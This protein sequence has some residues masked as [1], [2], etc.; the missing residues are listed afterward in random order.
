[1][2]ENSDKIAVFMYLDADDKSIEKD[3]CSN[4]LHATGELTDSIELYVYLDR[5]GQDTRSEDEEE[6]DSFDDIYTEWQDKDKKVRGG[7]LYGKAVLQPDNTWRIQ[8][9]T[10][11][12]LVVR[13]S[14]LASSLDDFLKWAEPQT[15]AGHYIVFMSDHGSGMQ[16]GFSDDAIQENQMMPIQYSSV[17][18][19][20]A[21]KLDVIVFD[22][23]L[24]ANAEGLGALSDVAR[25]AVASEENVEDT[26]LDYAAMFQNLAEL[27]TTDA[28]A[29][30]EAIVRG[31]M[32]TDTYTT[33]SGAPTLAAIRLSDQLTAALQTFGRAS[34]N[35]TE[36]DWSALV[37]AFHDGHHY[38]LSYYAD[39]VELM[40]DPVLSKNTSQT[41]RDA[42]SAL[43]AAVTGAVTLRKTGEE[44]GYG[45]TV[46]S[47]IRQ[48]KF[49]EDKFGYLSQLS[50]G[51]DT[52]WADFLYRLYQKA[53]AVDKVH[54]ELPEDSE[55]NTYESA[56]IAL[57]MASGPFTCEDTKQIALTGNGLVHTAN[58]N[59]NQENWL[60]FRYGGAF[61]LPGT[62]YTLN[63]T[64]SPALDTEEIE[65]GDIVI[66]AYAATQREDTTTLDLAADPFEVYENKAGSATI[67]IAVEN[68]K[69]GMYAL[70]IFSEKAVSYTFEGDHRKAGEAVAATEDRFDLPTFVQE[71]EASSGNHNPENAES[72][73]EY[74]CGALAVTAD[75]EEESNTDWFCFDSDKIP[76]SVIVTAFGTSDGVQL[77]V[78][79]LNVMLW[80]KD[81]EGRIV[82][83]A[84]AAGTLTP[85]GE[86]V[87]S[88]SDKVEFDGD[89][90]LSVSTSL[91]GAACYY[92]I[93]LEADDGEDGGG[94]GEEEEENGVEENDSPYSRGFIDAVSSMAI[95]GKAGS[96]ALKWADGHDTR[97]DDDIRY[98][99]QFSSDDF[100]TAFCI[101]LSH[102]AVKIYNVDEG[103]SYD[104]RVR[105]ML[106]DEGGKDEEEEEE[107]PGEEEK[108][109]LSAS[110][111]E[112]EWACADRPLDGNAPASPCVVEAQNDFLLDYLMGRANGT[113]SGGYM[114]KHVGFVGGWTGTGERAALYG[115]NR[116]TDVFKG[117]GED[118]ASLI[119][120]DDGNGDA[121][122]AD[123]IY[124]ARPE[125]W[126]GSRLIDITEV[127]AGAGD[128]IVDFTS[129]KFS[130]GYAEQ[131]RLY[132]GDG[133]D[134]LWAADTETMLFGDS[135][136]D[137][138]T[139]STK[140][141]V[142][143]G[144]SGNDIMT[145][146]GGS[147]IF[148][149][150]EN[151]GTDVVH[152]EEDG[153][154]ILWF[155]KAWG[156]WNDK[157]LTYSDGTNSVEVRGVAAD[158]IS[159]YIGEAGRKTDF[160]ELKEDLAFASHA[161]S[162][163]FG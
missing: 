150:C 163:I 156:T 51:N 132:G 129:R 81:E 20:Y 34:A 99:L 18:K 152:Q 24:M 151:W 4:L 161:S 77:D 120:T 148:C 6:E 127:Q 66:R 39:L 116:I 122:F 110:G 149:F 142:L 7:S 131:M 125:N 33:V 46:Y 80:D 54:R 49:P 98:E 47:P 74:Y 135:G 30:A 100:E 22:A 136:D 42:A 146:G 38:Y 96:F 158:D 70:Q 9:D 93:R 41:L 67:G 87:C 145:G 15:D 130:N 23:C 101:T 121:V 50:A 76:G 141:D 83:K 108:K 21:K 57:P 2:V 82:T 144:G 1:M 32:S 97:N 79:D 107:A 89:D 105:T 157:T 25:Y 133:N 95:P 84:T 71:E 11:G 126:N 112:T 73:T 53:K 113:W 40:T 85:S 139:G 75:T 55:V 8:W 59:V 36:D 16:G 52:P 60:C 48:D 28:R 14:S 115:K 153:E 61:S 109:M 64:F 118:A 58:Y 12:G 137:C 91:N 26:G 154:V 114:A 103:V 140:D 56:M 92:E 123:D 159:I 78:K 134:V 138:L 13:D 63:F 160:D 124:S 111:N 5:L 147:D 65:D 86:L 119:L 29:M 117:G 45:V 94:G 43:A 72:L 17:L 102:T 69:N 88:F 104:W 106:D 19:K 44:H 10:A 62:T 68:W 37:D 35:F 143:I 3:I 128:D 155:E 31:N 27:E 90:Y 162:R